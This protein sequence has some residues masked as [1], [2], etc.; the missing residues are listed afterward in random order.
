MTTIYDRRFYIIPVF[1]TQVLF[2]L[3]TSAEQLCQYGLNF[4][5][6]RRWHAA[7]GFD[8]A[9]IHVHNFKFSTE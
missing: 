3:L 7:Y 2:L 4:S 1:V 8:M 6:V 5:N 9:R